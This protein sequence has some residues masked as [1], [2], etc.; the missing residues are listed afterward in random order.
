MTVGNQFTFTERIESLKAGLTTAMAAVVG[1][2][3]SLLVESTLI[4]PVHDVSADAFLVWVVKVAIAMLSGF[5][6]GVTYRYVVRQDDNSHL[7]SG[8]VA[9]FVVVR[10]LAQVETLWTP[11][12]EL[13]DLSEAIFPYLWLIAQ[14]ICIFMPARWCLDFAL[15]QGWVKPFGQS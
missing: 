15:L 14:G 10:T 2:V 8:V 12:L 6:F 7:G 4:S 1:T 3:M 11:T 13:S 5:L 9:A